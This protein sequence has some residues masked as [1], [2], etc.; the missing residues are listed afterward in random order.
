MDVEAEI[1]DLKRR[2][3]E[4]EGSF[5]FLT[6]QVRAVHRDLLE[7]RTATEQPLNRLE[8]AQG[9]IEGRLDRVEG[10]LLALRDDLP[11]IV[12][13]AVGVALRSLPR[14]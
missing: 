14:Q 3:G 9:R 11:E 4:L 10:S 8:E 12:S 6:E 2:V 5:T 1:R 13:G 7:F